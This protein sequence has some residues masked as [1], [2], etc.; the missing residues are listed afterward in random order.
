MSGRRGLMRILLVPVLAIL[1]GATLVAF[2][3]PAS[4]TC[5]DERPA[6]TGT[7]IYTCEQHGTV[8]YPPYFR[9]CVTGTLIYVLGAP[10]LVLPDEC[11]PY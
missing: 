3:A 11:I 4:A 8:P 5:F 10:D 1:V 2:A 6:G 7:G 9:E